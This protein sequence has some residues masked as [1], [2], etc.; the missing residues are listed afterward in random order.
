MPVR[1]A[2]PRLRKTAASDLIPI[3][4]RDEHLIAVNKPAGLLVHRSPIDARETRF[5]LQEVREQIGAHVFPVHRLDKG[6][7][8]VLL[9]ALHAAAAQRL[10]EAWRD[11]QVEKR[12]LAVVRGWAEEHVLVDHPLRDPYDPRSRRAGEER[13][14]A[15]VSEFAC[16]ARIELE[17]AVGRYPTARYSLAE[18][19]PHTGRRHQLRRHL[20]HLRH[21]VIGDANY[22][23]GAHNRFFRNSL[24]IGRLLLA[25][26]RIRFRHP[27]GAGDVEIDAALEGEF[28][29]F[30]AR[31]E[32]RPTTRDEATAAEVAGDFGSSAVGSCQRTL[33]GPE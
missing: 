15:A 12:Y 32:W 29:A 28:A 9:F 17:A 31:P 27:F 3:L 2:T 7:S 16:L 18:C 1:T 4:Y 25:A 21:P 6:T 23:D 19:R 24:G 20:K 10:S 5:L 13:Q 22:G 33:R 11:E 8:G 14:R 26:T 30:L